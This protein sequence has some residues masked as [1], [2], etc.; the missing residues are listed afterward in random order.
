MGLG[1]VDSSLL[2][3]MLSKLLNEVIAVCCERL[4]VRNSG[5]MVKQ[6]GSQER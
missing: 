5:G 2:I 6:V 4:L 1:F 3:L